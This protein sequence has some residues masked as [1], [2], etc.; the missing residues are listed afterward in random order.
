MADLCVAG[1]SGV[2]IKSRPSA[3]IHRREYPSNFPFSK[4][5]AQCPKSLPLKEQPYTL[6]SSSSSTT[7]T[8]RPRPHKLAQLAL[9]NNQHPPPLLRIKSPLQP[10]RHRSRKQL[11][12]I[13]LFL[14][15]RTPHHIDGF[16][17]ECLGDCKCTNRE[18]VRMF[19][20]D[21]LAPS[22]PFK[23]EEKFESIRYFICF[24]ACLGHWRGKWCCLKI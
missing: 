11:L 8:V 5:I 3:H 16:E 20:G 19:Q 22:L 6:P 14:D 2:V 12:L 24:I 15:A 10:S 17:L 23:K 21:A 18:C 7:G 13:S 4:F 1:P 9:L